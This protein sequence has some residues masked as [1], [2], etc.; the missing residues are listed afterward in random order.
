MIICKTVVYETYGHGEFV[1]HNSLHL[2]VLISVHQFILSLTKHVYLLAALKTDPFVTF[3]SKYTQQYVY[4]LSMS[5]D[6][7]AN[8]AAYLNAAV[9]SDL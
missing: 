8:I 9:N 5:G 2:Y 7:L 4:H 6:F 3:S 1:L